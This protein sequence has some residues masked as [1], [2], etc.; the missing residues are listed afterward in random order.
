[1]ARYTGT[2]DAPRPP[3]E[4]WQYLADLRSIREWDPSVRAVSLTEGQPGKVGAAYEL[5]VE[6]MGRELI[7]PYRT[8]AANPP[9]SVVFAAE[10]DAVSVRDQATIRRGPRGSSVIWDANLELKGV[11]RLLDL[12]LR[13]AFNRLGG[14]AAHGLAERL[15][16]SEP[17]APTGPVRTPEAERA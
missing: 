5:T 15:S 3:Q 10:T 12:P 6:F 17:L 16:S 14:R 4:V 1:M 9:D 8:V 11:R 2:I 13:I 7:L